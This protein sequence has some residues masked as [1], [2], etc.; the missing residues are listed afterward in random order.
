MRPTRGETVS[1][2]NRSQCTGRYT[3]TNCG[4]DWLISLGR[5]CMHQQQK[6]CW[7][8]PEDETV[9]RLRRLR[10]AMEELR[11]MEAPFQVYQENLLE[12]CMVEGH[13]GSVS[14]YSEEFSSGRNCAV[15]PKEL[16]TLSSRGDCSEEGCNTSNDSRSRKSAHDLHTFR[17]SYC[18]QDVQ[19]KTNLRFSVFSESR[20][21]EQRMRPVL[22]NTC[23]RA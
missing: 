20:P 21:R 18:Q 17:E 14:S 10:R 16:E 22:T 5:S 6:N 2:R 23:N 4:G 11:W 19:S 8:N 1:K 7:W 15:Q 9:A 12:K 13:D 3:K